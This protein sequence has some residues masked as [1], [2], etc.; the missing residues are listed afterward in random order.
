MALLSKDQAL[1]AQDLHFETVSVPEWDGEIRLRSMSGSE[2][3][4]YEQ[5]FFADRGA[6]GK[7][8]HVRARLVAACAVDAEG[9]RLFSDADIVALGAK[10]ASALDRLFAAASKLNA[11]SAADVEALGK[12]LPPTTGGA[13]ITSS[14]NTST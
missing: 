11:V 10:S 9:N 3:D 8:A 4:A 2:R 7:V 1:A 13:F 12:G 14:Q 6:D 5:S